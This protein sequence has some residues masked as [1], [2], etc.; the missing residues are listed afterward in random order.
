MDKKKIIV[1]GVIVVA[2]I[3]FFAFDL[4]QYFTLES[5]KAQQQSLVDQYKKRK[6][7]GVYCGVPGDLHRNRCWFIA[8]HYFVN[9][10]GRCHIWPRTWRH[11]CVVCIDNWCDA[12]LSGV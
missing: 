9:A 1:V 4:Q 12:G 2:I 3:A 8:D 7:G 10:A 6:P 5:I 11:C